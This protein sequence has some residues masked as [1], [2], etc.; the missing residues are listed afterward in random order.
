MTEET[1]KQFRVFF[2]KAGTVVDLWSYTLGDV[3]K[4][5]GNPEEC[6]LKVMVP[7][8]GWRT[9]CSL[10]LKKITKEVKDDLFLSS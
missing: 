4:E 8:K 1:I 10:N 5:A 2:P 3:Y 7:G 6:E 9:V